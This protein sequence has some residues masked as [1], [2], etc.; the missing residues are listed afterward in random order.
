MFSIKN[1]IPALRKFN[2]GKHII[3]EFLYERS[4]QNKVFELQPSWRSTS[5]RQTRV[6]HSA[7]LLGMFWISLHN[8]LL[9][10]L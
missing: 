4:E 3:S 5:K 9:R 2:Y 7:Q 10:I 1:H 6:L 8:N